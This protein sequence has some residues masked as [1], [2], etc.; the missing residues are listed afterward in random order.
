MW[1]RFGVTPV[2]SLRWTLCFLAAHSLSSP[3]N[4]LSILRQLLG[5]VGGTPLPVPL[6]LLPAGFLQQSLLV[7]LCCLCL[8]KSFGQWFWAGRGGSWQ[9]ILKRK[10][11]GF[12]LCISL[13]AER[14]LTSLTKIW[15]AHTQKVLDLHLVAVRVSGTGCVMKNKRWACEEYS[16]LLILWLLLPSGPHVV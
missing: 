14:S 9:R 10:Y 11:L 13:E 8:A 3:P 5:S 7:W 2:S 16:A 15:E 12:Y 4:M 1:K 6:C